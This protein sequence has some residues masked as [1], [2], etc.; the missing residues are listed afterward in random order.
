M[1]Q[2]PIDND[3]NLVILLNGVAQLEC[4]SKAN[5]SRGNWY[6][7]NQFLASRNIMEIEYYEASNVLCTLITRYEICDRVIVRISPIT[8]DLDG[9]RTR[10]CTVLQLGTGIP[11]IIHTD[12]ALEYFTIKITNNPTQG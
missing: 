10:A 3:G 6:L 7:D 5:S 1:A 12:C 8:T 11:P 9:N 2:P 4:E